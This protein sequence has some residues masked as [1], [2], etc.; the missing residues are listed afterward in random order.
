MGSALATTTAIG[1]S[2]YLRRND[3]WKRGKKEAGDEEGRSSV[4]HGEVADDVE[5]AA[6]E[7]EE[8]IARSAL[9]FSVKR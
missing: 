3:L 2:A 5:V 8:E 4:L 7:H 1:M 6:G 9:G